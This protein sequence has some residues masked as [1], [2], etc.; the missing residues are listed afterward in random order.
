VL[1]EAKAHIDEMVT[2]ASSAS[3]QSLE[4]ILRSIA[5]TK[6]HIQARERSRWDAAFYQ[7]V[8]CWAHLYHLRGLNNVDAYLVF[9][10][11]TDAPKVPFAASVPE[12]KAAIRVVKA[13]LG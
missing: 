9:V 13:A 6:N 12:W 3:P 2:D 11:F 4:M 7:Y 10:Y 8:N 1:I 5:E